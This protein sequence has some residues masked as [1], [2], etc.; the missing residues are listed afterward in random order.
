[1]NLGQHDN[2]TASDST[3]TSE[4]EHSAESS[5]IAAEHVESLWREHE[6]NNLPRLSVLW[7]Y[8]RNPVSPQWWARAAKAVDVESAAGTNRP[9]R[10]AQERGLPAR[11]FNPSQIRPVWEIEANARREIVVEN[12]IAWRVHAMVDFLFNRPIRLASSVGEQ[13]L[14]DEINAAVEAMW[15]A[16]GGMSLLQDAALL[17]HV[18]GHVDLLIRRLSDNEQDTFASESDRA[19]ADTVRPTPR[20]KLLAAARRYRVEII[21]P[22]RGVPII[23][24]TDY[25]RLNAYV[26]RAYRTDAKTGQLESLTQLL[27]PEGS[28]LW[29]QRVDREGNPEGSPAV[30]EETPSLFAGRLPVVHVQNISQPMSYSGLSEVEPLIALQDE[31]NTRLSDRAN[32]VTMQCF[33]MYLAKGVEGFD[34]AAV[35]PGTV[36]TTDNEHARIEAFGGDSSS[37]SEE[38]HIDEIREAMDKTSGVPP[39]AAGVVRAKIGNLSSENAL[40]VTLQGLL[41]RTAR[42]RV[43][44]GR[45]IAQVCELL[46]TGLASEGELHTRPEQRRVSVQWPDALP[47]DVADELKAAQIKD[48]LGVERSRVLSD[49]GLGSGD[50]GVE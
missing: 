33:K 27:T 42:K 31:L 37:P 35:G 9:H 43:T 29:S 36:W 39:L 13:S 32:R 12:D 30:Q 21:D 15:E 3:I 16:S 46:L 19:G 44:W 20:E 11:F 22:T 47:R 2:N 41:T 7:S 14:A 26:I 48:E 6:T 17:A 40:R 10:S 45:A 18:Y 34:R 4:H 50:R 24:E 5:S 1:M 8:Y 38:S 25:R 49:L 23:S 28:R